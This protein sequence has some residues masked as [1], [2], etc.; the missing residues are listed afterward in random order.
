MAITM[1]DPVEVESREFEETSY[2]ESL[3]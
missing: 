1:I 2:R 3:S